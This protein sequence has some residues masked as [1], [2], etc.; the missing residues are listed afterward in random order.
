MPSGYLSRPLADRIRQVSVSAAS[1]PVQT[2]GQSF[3]LSLCFL[4]QHEGE[5]QVQH[6]FVSVR[7]NTLK[8]LIKFT[9]AV[10]TEV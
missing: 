5:L 7:K 2:D 4:P 6:V 3:P 10:V 8:A 1:L 9:S